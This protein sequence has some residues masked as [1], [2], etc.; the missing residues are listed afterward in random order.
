[1]DRPAALLVSHVPH[2]AL[3]SNPR[4]SYALYVPPG[5]YSHGAGATPAPAKLPLLVSVHGTARHVYDI[6]DSVPFAESTPCPILAPL[7]PAGLDGPN[8]VDSFFLV[9]FGGGGQFA[10]RF[11]YLYPERLAAVSIGAP[12]RST[13]LDERLGLAD[14]IKRVRVQLVIGDA[15]VDVHGGREFWA[16][17]QQMRAQRKRGDGCAS[18]EADE[19]PIMD[20]GRLDT[21][22]NLHE[23]WRRDGIVA[24]LDTVEGVSHDAMGVRECIPPFP[25]PWVQN[26]STQ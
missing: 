26:Q 14:L 22:R 20:Q 19:L 24:Q 1:M 12:G 11:L 10:L 9:G 18:D 21:L 6:Y 13:V 17:V 25:Q 3:T 2:R 8:D 7:F 4:V 5:H 23:S 16:W 15:D